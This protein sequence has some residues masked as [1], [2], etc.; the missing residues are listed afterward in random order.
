[1]KPFIST[2][3]Y[4]FF[5]YILSLTLIA[6]PWLFHLVNVSSAALLLPMYMGWLQLITTIFVDSEGSPIR[7]FP[8]QM[9]M[10]VDVIM[11]F[12]LIV[13]PWLYNFSDRAFLPELL[14]GGL[15]LFLGLFTMKSPFTT[16]PH[17]AVKEGGL[18]SLDSREGRLNV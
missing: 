6:S 14:L 9:N 4:G 5:K 3:F 1:M 13:S 12:I 2:A 17:R 15:L 10:V 16:K 7:Q 8:I 18:D 11:G